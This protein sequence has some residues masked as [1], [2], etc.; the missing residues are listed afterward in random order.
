MSNFRVGQK[1]V[2]ED[3]FVWRVRG[4]KSERSVTGLRVGAV[5]T[6]CAIRYL[7]DATYRGFAG[8]YVLDLVEVKPDGSW[9]GSKGFAARRFRPVVERK[10]DIS[11]F[12]A[13]LN[14]SKQ[15]V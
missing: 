5:Y 11:I 8:N 9:R 7:P 13:M 10:T 14:P 12:K 1:V 4:G 3:A 15:P 2:C 6:I